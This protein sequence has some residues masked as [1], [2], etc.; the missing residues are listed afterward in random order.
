MPTSPA[1]TG[2][3]AE[4]PTSPADQ[5]VSV[6]NESVRAGRPY[7]A[8]PAIKASPLLSQNQARFLLPAHLSPHLG[9]LAKSMTR[10]RLP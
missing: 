6:S 9:D 7:A 1:T 3:A 2:P 10:R 5:A 8:R 4:S